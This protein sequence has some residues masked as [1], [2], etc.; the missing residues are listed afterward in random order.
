[1]KMSKDRG[2]EL[3][4]L[5][6]GAAGDGILGADSQ[7]LL[8]GHI[9]AVVV[10]GAAGMDVEDIQ[11]SDVTL[12]TVLVD[13]SSSIGFSSLEATVREGYN[14]LLEAFA[15]SRQKDSILVAL[16]LFD[17]QATLSHSYVPVG[18]ATRLD[19]WNY[20]SSGG[21]ALHDTW[22]DALAANV[23][24]AQRLRDGGIPCRSIAV[25]ITDGEDTTST[26]RDTD[27][28]QLGKD[29]LA[30]EQFI[31]AF[32]GV[33]KESDF[34]QVARR[35]GIPSRCVLVEKSATPQGLR[36]AFHLVS[37]SVIRASQGKIL[38]G[39]NAGFFGP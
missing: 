24:Y 29:L 34:K 25:V 14:A 16:W 26:R 32:V 31:L 22:L 10:A 39:P 28:A 3:R 38:P 20:R 9:G 33:G 13:Q 8:T 27:C 37:Q 36:Q 17:D 21:T 19:S 23:A 35:M 5:F 12:I 18:D 6:A 2:N 30:S 1:M 11:A 4:D 7:S 15:G